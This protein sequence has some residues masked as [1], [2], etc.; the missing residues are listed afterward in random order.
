MVTVDI[1]LGYS[2]AGTVTAINV[3][4]AATTGHT[5]TDPVLTD[6]TTGAIA[7]A[8]NHANNGSNYHT[9]NSSALAATAN[10]LSGLLLVVGLDS[11]AHVDQ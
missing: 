6:R 5:G 1:H 2:T 4:F 8:I 3:I 11:P 7:T 9:D 10:Q